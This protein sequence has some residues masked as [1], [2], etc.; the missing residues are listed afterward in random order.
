MS[1]KI[2]ETGNF[3]ILLIVVALCSLVIRKLAF[4]SF[5][6]RYFGQVAF[7]VFHQN[8]IKVEYLHHIIELRIF[9]C[10]FVKSAGRLLSS[11]YLPI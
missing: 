9:S 10:L 6:I 2:S 3:T 4:A 1:C 7:L 11:S 5:R 8:C